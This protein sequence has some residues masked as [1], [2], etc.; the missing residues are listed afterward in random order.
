MSFREHDIKA[1]SITCRGRMILDEN[2]NMHPREM[3]TSGDVIINGNLTVRGTRDLQPASEA[4]ERREQAYQKRVQIAHNQYS[5]TPPT[6]TNNG[7]EESC[8]DFIASYSKSLAHNA[9]GEPTAESYQ[10]FLHAIRTGRQDDYASIIMGHPLAKLVNPQAALAYDTQ[11]ADSHALFQPPAPTFSSAWRAGEGVED[12]WM[13]LTRDIAFTDYLTHPLIAEACADLNTLSDFRGPKIDG[14]VTPAMIFRQSVPGA[15]T[16][17]F[18]SQFLYLDCPYGAVSI[19]QKMNTPLPGSINEFNTTLVDWLATQNGQP[20]SATLSIDGTR[21]YIRNGRDLG[22]WV[23]IDVLNQLAM[24]AM[25]VLFS[26][27][28]PLNSGNP[29]NNISNQYGFA[30]FGGPYVISMIAEVCSRA[31]KSQWF[32]KWN[33]HRTLRPEEYFGRVDRHLSGLATYPI[34]SDA[35][36]SDAVSKLH[37]ANGTWFLPLAYPEGSPKHPAYGSGHATVAGATVTIL[38]AFFNGSFTI[39]NPK[40]PNATGTALE[41]Y[42]GPAL[43]VTHELNKLATNIA[44]GRCMAGVHWRS[45]SDE[46]LILGEKVAIEVL[47]DQKS[48]YNEAFAG[49]TFEK[50]DGTTI[51][52]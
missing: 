18:I 28:C 47:R 43:T 33:V 37:D 1:K 29:Y 22:E 44:Q 15:L 38:K 52:I 13:A 26:I 25:L 40:I 11:G 4:Q 9:N 19:N 42:I 6:H 45:D 10:S 21:R 24:H 35:L 23:H 50:F 32:Q 14:L 30:T 3:K 46:S 2:G 7:D 39:P 27:N 20:P 51:T 49:F 36:D 17:P 12:V 34:H 31:L 5:I 41:D 8:P 48:L 16:G